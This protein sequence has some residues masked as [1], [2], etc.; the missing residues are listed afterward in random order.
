MI[1]ELGQDP[2]AKHTRGAFVMISASLKQ[3]S[4]INGSSI[5]GEVSAVLQHTVTT[6]QPAIRLM[7]IAIESH[8]QPRSDS[9]IK[10][11][12]QKTFDNN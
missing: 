3:L 7:G 9:S 4:S 1:E 6:G 2:C 10:F 8:A 11:N 12:R 5:V